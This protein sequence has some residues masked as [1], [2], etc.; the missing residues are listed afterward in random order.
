MV[1]CVWTRY[2]SHYM[3]RS[4][5]I[6]C[7]L[8]TVCIVFV[9]VAVH[10]NRCYILYILLWRAGFYSVLDIE[11]LHPPPL[12][13]HINI[14]ITLCCLY[15]IPWYIHIKWSGLVQFPCCVYTLSVVFSTQANGVDM[16]QLM[17]FVLDP[18]QKHT[19]YRP[20]ALWEL[21]DDIVVRAYVA[22]TKSKAARW[23]WG[24][25]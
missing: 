3:A 18:S 23:H 13:V 1:I 24:A 11:Y 15:N 21:I 2:C 6:V 17:W 5:V 9:W 8:E 20:A 12:N 19:L 25:S 7:R 14:H 10:I 22:N 16:Y 4:I